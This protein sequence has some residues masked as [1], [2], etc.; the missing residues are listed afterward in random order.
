MIIKTLIGLEL[1]LDQHK[2]FNYI[3][4]NGAEQTVSME[5]ILLKINEE[6][7]LPDNKKLILDS[8]SGNTL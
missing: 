3:D 6:L 2:N 5:A 4:S 8:L 1:K 7:N